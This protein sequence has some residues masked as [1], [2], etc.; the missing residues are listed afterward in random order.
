LEEN[1]RPLPGQEPFNQED[2]I[3]LKHNICYRDNSTKKGKLECDKQML[4]SLS[5][6][7]TKGIWKSFDKRLVPSS[8]LD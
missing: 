4:D 5:Q 2:T 3:A 1:D 6:K 7:K 8:N